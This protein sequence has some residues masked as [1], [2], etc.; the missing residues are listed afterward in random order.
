M[1]QGLTQIQ[2]TVLLF[3]IIIGAEAC[4]AGSSPLPDDRLGIRTAPLLLLSR[5]DMSE[6]I[7]DR[8]VV[9]LMRTIRTARRYY[10]AVNYKR[11]KLTGMKYS[12]EH[13]SK[14]L[15]SP[16][17]RNATRMRTKGNANFFMTLD[18][19]AVIA[20]GTRSRPR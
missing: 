5:P 10:G 1:R 12:L 3:A 2:T 6:D 7:A 9:V 16:H 17:C 8:N 4:R 19:I 11:A 15:V 14:R 13:V 20:S 18:C